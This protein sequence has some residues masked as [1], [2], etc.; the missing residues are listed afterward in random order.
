MSNIEIK[1]LHPKKDIVKFLKFAWKIYEGDPNWVP[2]LRTH[3]KEMVGFKHHPFHDLADTQAFLALHDGVPSGRILAIHNRAHNEFRPDEACGFVGFFESID[4]Q[5]VAHGLFD[6]AWDWCSGRGLWTQPKTTGTGG[7]SASAAWRGCSPRIGMHLCSWTY[8]R[9]RCR[10]Y[11]RASQRRRA[12]CIRR[13][14]GI[15]RP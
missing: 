14:P 5:E 7:R 6:A 10:C 12:A 11:R 15:H 13:D 1:A 2:P 8:P 4:D 3:Q 9:R